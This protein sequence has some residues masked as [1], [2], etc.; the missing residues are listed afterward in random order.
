MCHVTCEEPAVGKHFVGGFLILVVAFHHAGALHGKL[1]DLALGNRLLLIVHD[2]DLPA[3]ACLSDR[4]DLVDVLHAKM[5]ASRS[6]GLTQSV[7]GVVVMLG[8]HGFPTLDEA[9][10][11]GLCADV[12]QTPRREIVV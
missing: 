8:E 10:R 3:V 1:T 5:Y 4:T 11:H 9:G 12:H 7:V 2:S 6:D